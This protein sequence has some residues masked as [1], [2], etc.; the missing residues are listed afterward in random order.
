MRPGVVADV[1]NSRIKW[2]R[3]GADSIR[4]TCSLPPD[5]P[6]SWEQQRQSW[7][8]T[9]DCQW[10]VTGVHPPR[11]EQFIAWLHQRGQRV[12]KLDKPEDL[13]L[14]VL[15]ARPDQVGVDRLLDAVAANSRRSPG[16]PA[17]IIDAGS[18]VTVDLVDTSGA[19][20]GGAIVPGLRLMAQA[21]HDHTALLPLVEPPSTVDGAGPPLPGTSTISAIEVGIFWAVVGGIEALLREYR[22][23][24][25]S[26][27][28]VFL[29]GGDGPVLH[30]FLPDACL[31]TEMT[32]EG[33]RLGAEAML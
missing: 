14:R 1:G 25:G 29:T 32:L 18:A 16:V 31:W 23:H 5:D 13:T 15:V 7:R 26:A 30:P 4:E 17:V 11:R 27:V 12:W 9:E 10:V 22:R 33:V 6:S 2:G 3:C 8:L 20:A 24:C 19:F 28:Q 21:L